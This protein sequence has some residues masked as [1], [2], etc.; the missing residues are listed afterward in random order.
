MRS[1]TASSTTTSA[2]GSWLLS[3]FIVRA[4]A[5]EHEDEPM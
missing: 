2:A 5:E 1:R 3:C 4:D